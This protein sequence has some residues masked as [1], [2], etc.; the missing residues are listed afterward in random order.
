MFS[1]T[2]IFINQVWSSYNKNAYCRISDD[3]AVNTHEIYMNGD[4][5]CSM[6]YSVL[7]DDAKA[8]KRPPLDNPTR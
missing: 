3:Y 2:V 8:T 6:V 5:F 1:Y 7:R 4:W